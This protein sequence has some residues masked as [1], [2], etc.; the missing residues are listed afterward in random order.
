MQISQKGYGRL[1][2]EQDEQEGIIHETYFSNIV[3]DRDT[4]DANNCTC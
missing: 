2:D 3:T 4:Y 1:F